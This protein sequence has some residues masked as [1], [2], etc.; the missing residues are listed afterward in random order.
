MIYAPFVKHVS[1]PLYHWWHGSDLIRNIRTFE[2]SQWLPQERLK[3][4]QW[5]RLSGLLEHAYQHV[6][7]YQEKFREMGAEPRDFRSF[8][9]FAKFP[10]MTKRTLQER[11]ADLTASNIP[12]AELAKGIT[13]G[14]SGQPTTYIQE[15]SSNRIRTAAGKRLTGIAGYELGQKLFYLWRDSPFVI[16][17]DQVRLATGTHQAPSS[18]LAKLK[19]AIHA[20]VGVDNQ[21]LRVDPTLMT[22]PEMGTMYERLRAFQ[23]DVV[24]SY[25]STLYM[26][27]Q[28]MEA[29]GLGGVAPRSVIVSSETLYPHQRELLERVFGCPVYN[30]YG[31]SETGI[32]A[33]E[34]PVREGL[35]LNQEILHMESVTDSAGN[36]QLIVTDLINRGMPLL[37]YETG[38]T[39]RV[40]EEC[41]SCGRGLSRI[42]DLSGRI[43][44]QLPTRMGGYVNGQLFATFHWIEGVKQYQVIQEKLDTFKI[45]IV[46]AS[47]FAEKNLAPMLQTIHER[48]GPDTSI[49]VEYVEHI[50]FTRGGKYKLVVSEVKMQEASR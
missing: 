50:P 3:A 4:M 23:P 17:G 41:C 11:L 10:T 18:G 16:E 36:S 38:D 46:R 2:R 35:H 15:K 45:R 43:I 21:T 9:D 20:R 37:R 44:D 13:S 48:F 30:R 29:N 26:F 40:I 14:S 1:L 47:S 12:R 28:Y 8:D 6:P 39:G 34:C 5:E 7:Y 31:L 49:D 42:V 32:V 22:E 19:Q 24:I 25:V 27:A 33:I